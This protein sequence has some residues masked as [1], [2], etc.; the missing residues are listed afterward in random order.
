VLARAAM[1]VGI[2]GIFMET[3]PDPDQ[4]LSDGPNAWPLAKMEALLETLMALDQVTKRNGFLE[5][6]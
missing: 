2:A 4:A 3:H 1:A 5:S 6:T